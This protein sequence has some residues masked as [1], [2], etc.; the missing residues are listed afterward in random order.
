M[1]SVYIVN[2]MHKVERR[3]FK[4][5]AMNTQGDKVSFKKL[6]IKWS[7]VADILKSNHILPNTTYYN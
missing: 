6:H 3:M 2:R 7:S 1:L 5:N 4:T